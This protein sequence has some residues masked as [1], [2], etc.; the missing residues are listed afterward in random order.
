MEHRDD[1]TLRMGA[2]AAGQAPEE[3]DAAVQVQSKI[4]ELQRA[5]SESH[6]KRKQ[7]EETLAA[8]KLMEEVYREG[9]LAYYLTE[10]SPKYYTLEHF[11]DCTAQVY[12]EKF[13]AS[14]VRWGCDLFSDCDW[15]IPVLRRVST[16]KARDVCSE[17]EVQILVSYLVGLVAR[18]IDPKLRTGIERNIDDVLPLLLLQRKSQVT[19]I[20]MIIVKSPQRKGVEPDLLIHDTTTRD[21]SGKLY[22]QL[23]ALKSR[24][25]VTPLIMVTDWNF[26]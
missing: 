14:V 8:R 1:D 17:G 25:L 20:G 22:D 19:P 10:V 11:G 4:E 26:W 18:T 9:F 13:G 2:P 12:S 15:K 5:L 16:Q 6:K 24:G 7:L 3:A 21:A 23:L